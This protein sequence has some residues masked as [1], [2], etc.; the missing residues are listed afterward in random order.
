MCI[1]DSDLPPGQYTVA[2]GLWVQAE[3]WRLPVFDEDGAAVGDTKL[4]FTLE[5]E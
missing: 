5:V 4:L 1:R 3:G 2:A